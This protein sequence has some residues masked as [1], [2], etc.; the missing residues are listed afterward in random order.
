MKMTFDATMK[1]SPQ[2]MLIDSED[3]YPEV[4]TMIYD[5]PRSSQKFLR[6]ED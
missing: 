5:S 6:K 1:T 3:P 2:Y 4:K